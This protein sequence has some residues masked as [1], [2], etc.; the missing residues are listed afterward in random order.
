MLNRITFAVAALVLTLCSSGALATTC[1]T[2]NP[3]TYVTFANGST[4]DASQVM[5]DLDYLLYCGNS[6]LAPLAG[7]H[8]TGSVGINTTA[9]N[10]WL[11]VGVAGNNAY[12]NTVIFASDSPRVYLQPDSTHSNWK[13]AAQ[14]TVSGGLTI[15]FGGANAN[16]TSST[17]TDVLTVLDSG[18]VGIG[19][20]TPDSILSVEGNSNAGAVASVTNTN[21]GSA[22]LAE[23]DI[24]N[25]HSATG[26]LKLKT[27][28]TGWTT[29]GFNI[30]DSGV[31]QAGANLSGGLSIVTSA[32]API[33]FYT[34][35]ANE[36]VRIDSSGNV[37]IGTMTPGQKLDVA[38]TIRQS[39]CTMAGTLSA[40]T[41]GNIICTSDGR[42]KN[43]LSNYTTGLEALA[44]ITP[45]LFTYKPT[46][47]DPVETFVHAGFIAQNVMAVIPQASALQHD[48]YYSLDTTAVLAATVNSVK[49]LKVLADRQSAEIAQLKVRLI[50]AN[51][52]LAAASRTQA[53]AIRQLQSQVGNLLRRTSLRTAA[54]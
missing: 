5:G 24:R 14:D 4:A 51:Q 3:S 7:P 27:L 41:S 1:S 23:F 47:S 18:N 53:D 30:Q 45:K 44:R 46:A 11:Q 42:L 48:G 9:P 36:R 28:G 19:T 25:E 38:G 2:S 52:Q 26:A 16:P 29:S 6:I 39:S 33:M 40:D 32:A 37:G 15:A 43:V 13:I 8:F 10:A 50:A 34:N 54:K 49:Q 12:R 21:S 35:G 17:Y 22:A 20:T 31:V